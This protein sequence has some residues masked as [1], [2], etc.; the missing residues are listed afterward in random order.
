VTEAVRKWIVI[1]LATFGG[2]VLA[3]CVFVLGLWCWQ[4]HQAFV[5]IQNTIAQQQAAQALQNAPPAR[6]APPQPTK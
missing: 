5:V 1:G 4:G 3:V 6:P 2:A